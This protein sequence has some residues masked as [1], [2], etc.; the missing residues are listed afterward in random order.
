MTRRYTTRAQLG[1]RLTLM[2]LLTTVL[3]V[4]VAYGLPAQQQ[5][6]LGTGSAAPASQADKAL[7]NEWTQLGGNPQ[8]THAVSIDVPLPWNV[9]W[10]WNGPAG[11]GDGPPAAGHIR[12]PQAVQPVIGNGRLYVG[13]NDGIV[14]AISTATGQQLW[15]RDVEAAVVNT[16]AYDPGSDSLYVGTL[17]GRL[18]RLNAS[19]GQT[20]TTPSVRPGGE[21]RMAPLLVGDTV[22]VGSTSGDLYAF[23]KLT[24]AQRWLYQA[25]AALVG[26]TAYSA[27]HGGIIILLAEDRSVHAV[28]ISDG[29]RLWRVT[30]NADPDP[31]RNNRY[32]NDTYPV[33]SDIN[34]V[35][36]I[37]SYFDWDKT[38]LPAGG[39]PSSV[40]DIRTWL[41]QNPTYQSF[42][43]LRLSNGSMPFV[44]PVMG[45]AIGNGGD[46]ESVPPQAVVK[47][48]ATGEEVAYLLW[49]NRQS[50]DPSK[51]CDG[52][53]DTTLGE[54]DLQT[55]NIRFVQ[56]HKNA[57]SMRMPTDE[58]SPL[59]M[60]GNTIFNTHWMMLGAIRI[61]DRSGGLGGSYSN[62][63][64]ATELNPVINTLQSGTCPGRTNH[65]CPTGMQVPGEG[66][67]DPGFYVYYHNQRVYDL[68]WTTTVRGVTVSNGTI[69]FKTVDGAIIALATAGTIPDWKRTPTP[70]FVS[71]IRS[72]DRQRIDEQY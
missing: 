1:A 28:R 31:L 68:F 2:L 19:T 60:A 61:T 56:S 71:L 33:V 24:L 13:D 69:Y 16:A 72:D 38:W 52:R 47:R 59:T 8:R 54:M 57:G 29:T 15:Q 70:F 36:I 22:Y 49:R 30:V 21:I 44:A 64:R 3:A 35:V 32:F 23:D 4:G 25:G 51:P 14:R 46:Y 37:R 66:T 62:P 65:R 26:S 5:P 45:G 41:T 10:I 34:D 7:V 63:I 18:W 39:A 53:E 20:F 48:L 67:M 11:G 55:G 9:K 17:G 43:V 40:N 42:F 50:C 6:G 12:L 27:N 58:Q